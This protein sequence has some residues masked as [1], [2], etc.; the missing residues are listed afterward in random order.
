MAE[1]RMKTV[2]E[3]EAIRRAYYVEGMKIR[4]IARELGYARQTVAR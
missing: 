2:E 3:R 4:Q 1:E